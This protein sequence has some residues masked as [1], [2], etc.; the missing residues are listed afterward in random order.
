MYSTKDGRQKKSKYPVPDPAKNVARQPNAY[1][2]TIKCDACGLRGHPAARCYALATAI[3][4]QKFLAQRTNEET[5]QHALEFWKQCNAPLIH[6]ANTKEPLT[7]SPL[8][9]LRTYLNKSNM[10]VDRVIDEMDWYYFDEGATESEVFG[11]GDGKPRKD[12]MGDESE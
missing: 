5:T 4:V 8:Q 1:D 2:A 12:S 7:K 6:D 3:Y 10:D 9:V 11:V